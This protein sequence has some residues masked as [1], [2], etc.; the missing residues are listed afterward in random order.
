MDPREELLFGFEIHSPEKIARALKADSK[1]VRDLDGQSPLDGLVEMYLRSSRFS[2]CVQALLDHGVV[3]RDR[4]ARVADPVVAA[5]MD[6]APG[7]PG[8]LL[9]WRRDDR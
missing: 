6:P 7:G 8:V 1:L 3:C 2:A 9:C 4:G 5:G